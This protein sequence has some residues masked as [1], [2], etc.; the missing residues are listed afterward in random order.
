MAGFTQGV[1]QPLRPGNPEEPEEVVDRPGIAVEQQQEDRGGRHHRG[2]LGQE[3]DGPK[4]ARAAAYGGQQGGQRERDDHLQRDCQQGVEEGVVE[5]GQY[6]WVLEQQL[7]VRQADRCP[8]VGGQVVV[9]ERQTQ[10]PDHRDDRE[11]SEPHD[12]GRDEQQSGDRLAPAVLFA[13]ATSPPLGRRR[14]DIGFGLGMSGRHHGA[15]PSRRPGLL[16]AGLGLVPGPQRRGLRIRQRLPGGSFSPVSATETAL[17]K[18]W[19]MI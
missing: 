4:H 17:L 10:A 6:L 3:E 5:R 14:L 18:F 13:L 15:P 1:G 2:H 19:S 12:P 16:L 9:G 7:V 8:P 11:D